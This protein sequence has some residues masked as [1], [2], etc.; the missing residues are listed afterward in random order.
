MPPPGLGSGSA[1]VP[2]LPA[3]LCC[4]GNQVGPAA[5]LEETFTMVSSNCVWMFQVQQ[6]QS[7][8]LASL[9]LLLPA[10]LYFPHPASLGTSVSDDEAVQLLREQKNQLA[11]SSCCSCLLQILT[12]AVSVSLWYRNT[13]DLR[14][15]SKLQSSDVEQQLRTSAAP[16]ERSSQQEVRKVKE[17]KDEDEGTSSF[18]LHPV[19]PLAS[20][21]VSLA[22]C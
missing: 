22:S 17:T 10:L 9:P 11:C 21:L 13:A 4:A 7:P 19:S 20:Q 8:A 1:V 5:E 3:A 6:Q 2:V 15:F 14:R 12:A 18:S 16:Q